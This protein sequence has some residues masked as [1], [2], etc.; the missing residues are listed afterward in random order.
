MVALASG[1]FLS[2]MDPDLLLKAEPVRPFYSQ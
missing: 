2:L 1:F